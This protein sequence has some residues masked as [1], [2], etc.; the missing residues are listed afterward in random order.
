MG[1]ETPVLPLKRFFSASA[2][3]FGAIVDPLPLDVEPSGQ[4]GFFSLADVSEA[5]SAALVMFYGA[6]A[7][8]TVTVRLYAWYQVDGEWVPVFVLEALVTMGTL[9]GKAAGIGTGNFWA[10][11]IAVQSQG[12]NDA[13]L[14]VMSPGGN[15]VAG[16]KVDPAGAKYLSAKFG[17]TATATSAN[18]V[19]KGF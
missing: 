17:T 16:I 12:I 11:T 19:G 5:F 9:A 18:A 14:A 1:L 15:R 13:S 2:A 6:A 7:S 8:S 3:G 4:D 10:T